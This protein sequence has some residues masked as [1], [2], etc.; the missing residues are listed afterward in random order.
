[1]FVPGLS[2]PG[3]YTAAIAGAATLL[4]LLPGSLPEGATGFNASSVRDALS[5]VALGVSLT[6]MVTGWGAASTQ[7]RTGTRSLHR[8]FAGIGILGT[9]SLTSARFPETAAGFGRALAGTL[10]AGMG[11]TISAGLLAAALAWPTNRLETANRR[12]VGLL[13]ALAIAA[14]LLVPYSAALYGASPAA[15]R[16]IAVGMCVIALLIYIRAGLKLYPSRHLPHAD[17]V[18]YMLAA[19]GTGLLAEALLACAGGDSDLPVLVADALRVAGLLLAYAAFFHQAARGP[20]IELQRAEL[21]LHDEQRRLARARRIARLGSWEWQLGTNEVWTSEEV[22]QMFGIPRDKAGMTRSEFENLIYREDV[23][24]LRAAAKAALEDGAPYSVDYRILGADG[25]PR[26]MH[27]EA[28]VERDEGGRPVRMAGIVQDITER[29]AVEHALRESDA[30]IRR[31]NAELEER[32]E[33]RTLQLAAANKELEA[34]SYSVSHDLQAPLRRIERYAEL[35]SASNGARLDDS[36]RD[37]LRRIADA[38]SQT[39][40]LIADV[41]KLSQVSRTEIRRVAVDLSALALRLLEQFERSTTPA[42]KVDVTVDSGIVVEAD[43]AMLQML[44]DNLL[45]NAWKF[46]ARTDNPRIRVGAIE[47]AEGKGFYV[48][49]NGAGFDM[50]YHER[51]F[52]AFQRLHSQEEFAGTGIGLAIVQRIV[53]IHGWQIRAVGETGRGATFTVKAR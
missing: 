30:Q 49:D 34:F 36:G 9:A 26:T 41:L 27:S 2:D 48:S 24:R 45:G 29:V 6:A 17:D 40:R 16:A 19:I 7:L 32:V 38:T 52:G 51:L 47:P 20:L 15:L 5:M 3:I 33:Q 8:A 11:L 18:R 23:A 43:S 53:N 1:M 31:M 46:T 4:S 28:Q 12:L 13:P 25:S 42:R 44:L 37:M 10:D 50:R 22:R 39:K 35:L 14:G 21:D